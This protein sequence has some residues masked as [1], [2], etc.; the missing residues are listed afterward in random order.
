MD[1]MWCFKCW[2]DEMGCL[3]LDIIPTV[4]L[5]VKGAEEKESEK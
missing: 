5:E 2:R 3:E 4:K 1:V